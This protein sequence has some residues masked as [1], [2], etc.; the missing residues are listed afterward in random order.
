MNNCK[1]LRNNPILLVA[2]VCTFLGLNACAWGQSKLSLDTYRPFSET[3]KSSRIGQIIG[4]SD[5]ENDESKNAFLNHFKNYTLSRWLDKSNFGSIPAF[6]DEL[7]RDLGRAK[8]GGKPHDD[9]VKL[10]YEFCYIVLAD[11][12]SANLSVV[13]KYNA[14]LLLGELREK[15]D[16]DART[17]GVPYG[18]A[19]TLCLKYASDSKAPEYLQIGAMKSLLS[20]IKTQMTLEQKKEVSTLIYKTMMSPIDANSSDGA[21]WMKELGIEGA[22]R[23]GETGDKG[24]VLMGLC[25]I[26]QDKTLPLSTRVAAA[27]SLSSYNYSSV[28][29]LPSTPF[30]LAL[31]AMIAD[32]LQEELE[33]PTESLRWQGQTKQSRRNAS[34]DMYGDDMMQKEDYKDSIYLRQRV[35]SPLAAVSVAIRGDSPSR[36]LGGVSDIGSEEEKTMI[37]RMGE[38]VDKLI[39]DLK[40]E[41]IKIETV[42]ELLKKNQAGFRKI[43]SQNKTAQ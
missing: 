34:M 4:N 38:L 20:F 42:T 9:A 12:K 10:V 22:R 18:P 35:I 29:S 1:L 15:E 5:Y 3:A 14:M 7:V 39:R 41:E 16:P 32:G 21:I 11:P 28:S 26:I 27:S 8:K 25:K 17:P 40:K 24:N 23:I 30:R 36:G 19:L 37:K 33:R 2:C 31:A 13:I 43:A 6:R